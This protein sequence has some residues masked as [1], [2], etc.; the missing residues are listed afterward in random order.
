M[1]QPH[2]S[3]VYRDRFW[4][5]LTNLL[6]ESDDPHRGRKW[7]GHTDAKI[8]VICDGNEVLIED[9][10]ALQFEVRNLWSFF[11]PVDHLGGGR[12]DAGCSQIE[13]RYPWDRVRR[14]G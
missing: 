3:Y 8:V 13:A 9:R 11:I 10:Q 6:P 7:Y 14:S 1:A 5:Q 2:L 12:D 4:R